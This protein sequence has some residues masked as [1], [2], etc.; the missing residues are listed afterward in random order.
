MNVWYPFIQ[1]MSTLR[2]VWQKWPSQLIKLIFC[3]NK[4]ITSSPRYYSNNNQSAL[5]NTFSDRARTTDLQTTTNLL[6]K[7]P[8]FCP[9]F[10]PRLSLSRIKTS[11]LN[12]L[13]KGQGGLLS[14]FSLENKLFRVWHDILITK[15]TVL[16]LN[17]AEICKSWNIKFLISLN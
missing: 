8:L 12:Y 17:F 5:N 2:A 15:V 9:R 10:F 11:I 3:N 13:R 7:C 1:Y 4:A 16:T 6:L 14:K